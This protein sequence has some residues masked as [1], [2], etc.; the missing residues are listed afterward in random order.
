MYGAM[1]CACVVLLSVVAD[2]Y[3]RRDNE[4]HYRTLADVGKCIGWG[5]FGLSIVSVLA[6]KF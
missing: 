4:Q 6:N 2:H 1:L 3:D 5:L